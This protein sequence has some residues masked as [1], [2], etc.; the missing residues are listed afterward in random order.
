MKR[1]TRDVTMRP[2]DMV[3]FGDDAPRLGAS[4][5]GRGGIYASEGPGP[6]VIV[7]AVEGDLNRATAFWEGRGL[8][9]SARDLCDVAEPWLGA[10]ATGRKKGSGSGRLWPR[11]FIRREKWL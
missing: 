6:V 8:N 2:R 5:A 7:K 4:P 11:L 9:V 10:L 1:T 3:R